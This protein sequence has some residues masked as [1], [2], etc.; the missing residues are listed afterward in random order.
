MGQGFYYDPNVDWYLIQFN[1][2]KAILRNIIEIFPKIRIDTS[3]HML[4]FVFLCL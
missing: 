2:I 1:N 4:Y 3:S